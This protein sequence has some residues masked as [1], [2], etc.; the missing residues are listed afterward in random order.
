VGDLRHPAHY[1]R[2]KVAL[3]V[4]PKKVEAKIMPQRIKS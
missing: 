1:P 3:K 2:Y 4:M